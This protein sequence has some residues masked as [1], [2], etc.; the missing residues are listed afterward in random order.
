MIPGPRLAVPDAPGRCPLPPARVVCPLCYA[1]RWGAA[2]GSIVC[3]ACGTPFPHDGHTADLTIGPAF[4][5]GTSDDAMCGDEAS[6]R[7]TVL[8]Y[9][10]PLFRSVWPDPQQPPSILSV[11]CGVGVDVDTLQEHGFDSMG[12]DCGS[13]TRAWT[14]RTHRD[15]LVRANG[16]K[17]PFADGT[18]D[19]TFCGCV[20]PHVGVVGDTTRPAAT[21][22][23]D[24][25]ALAREMVRVLKP[26]GRIFVSGANRLCPL[27]LFHGR[28]PGEYVPRLNPPWTRFLLSAGDYRRLFAA[29]GADGARTLAVRGY[30]G[31]VTSR[32]TVKGRMFSLPVRFAFRVLSYRALARLRG[33]FVDPWIVVTARKL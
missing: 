2:A 15:R 26:G 25:L 6:N 32:R 1:T 12:V 14:R 29:A 3:G 7:E 24:R 13:R 31:F 8:G 16:L 4:D 27:D 9:W 20:Y 18:F 23:E 30:W 10:V 33:S 11:G 21:H 19:A 5:D 22:G 17:L 28:A